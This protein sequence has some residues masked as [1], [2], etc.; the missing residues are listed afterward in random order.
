MVG[1][2]AVSREG[3]GVEH[4]LSDRSVCLIDLF[5]L[6][7]IPRRV[8]SGGLPPPEYLLGVPP[9]GEGCRGEVCKFGR[10]NSY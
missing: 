6:Q 7:Y 1:R 9:S 10:S 3:G 5:A 4:H 8:P 2:V